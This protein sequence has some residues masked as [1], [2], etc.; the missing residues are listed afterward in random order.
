MSTSAPPT[1]D[2]LR[3]AFEQIL[4]GADDGSIPSDTGLDDQTLVAVER[5]HGADSPAATEA[6]RQ[7]LEMQIDGTHDREGDA[8]AMAIFST[9]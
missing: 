1:D 3:A 4:T 8:A 2:E 7:E 6:A 5:A 9:P